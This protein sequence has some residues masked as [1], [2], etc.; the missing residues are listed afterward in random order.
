MKLLVIVA[1][2]VCGV[3]VAGCA[4]TPKYTQAQLN[5]IETREV[6]ASMEETF[7]AATNALF[8]AGYTI[9]MSDRP[10]GIP[11]GRVRIARAPLKPIP[12]LR[13]PLESVDL[14]TR[15]PAA[16]AYERPDVAVV[17]A[18]G[19]L[20][21]N[22]RVEDL[23]LLLAAWRL[24]AADVERDAQQTELATMAVHARRVTHVLPANAG[25]RRCHFLTTPPD[26]LPP[27]PP[28]EPP[29]EQHPRLPR[30][31]P[32]L[33]VLRLHARGGSKRSARCDRASTRGSRRLPA[34]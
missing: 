27:R 34:P 26:T 32:L 31:P 2:L 13:K 20:G 4:T 22:A 24:G 16:A 33:P 23:D 5:S 17:P 28:L 14:D 1:A 9:A 21:A 11:T 3:L 19:V 6:D 12:T 29:Q 7:S 10:G 8:A 18:A 25:L 15:E 30:C